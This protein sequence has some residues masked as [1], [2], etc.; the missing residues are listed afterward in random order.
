MVFFAMVRG[1]VT[2]MVTERSAGQRAE[3]DEFVVIGTE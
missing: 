1:I 3:G 2:V